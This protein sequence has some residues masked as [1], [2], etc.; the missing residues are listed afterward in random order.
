M[1]DEATSESTEEST[2]QKTFPQEYVHELREEAKGYREALSEY[3]KVFGDEVGQT[4]KTAA[5]MW[6]E[7]PEAVAQWMAENAKPFLNDDDDEDDVDDDDDAAEPFVTIDML[8]EVLNER[9]ETF[10]EAQA[11]AELDRMAESLGYSP[12]SPEYVELLWF[13][14]NETEGDLEAADAKVKERREA[15]LSELIDAKKGERENAAS[16]PPEGSG[17]APSN[18]KPITS[19]GDARASAEARIANAT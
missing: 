12:D 2:E 17:G 11:L 4:W 10:Q 19:W 5:E 1:A 13:A 18:E 6:R 16:L 14:N 9:D 7:N 15:L 3:E 8:Q